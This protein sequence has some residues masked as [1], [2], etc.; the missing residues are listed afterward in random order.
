MLRNKKEYSFSIKERLFLYKILIDKKVKPEYA[1][2][3]CNED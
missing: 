1:L 2:E 3:L